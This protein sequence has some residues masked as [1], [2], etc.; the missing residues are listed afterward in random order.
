MERLLRRRVDPGPTQELPLPL[1]DSRGLA[2]RTAPRLALEDVVASNAKVK[3]SLILDQG[4]ET[5]IR[6]LPP[7]LVHQLV[8]VYR[9]AHSGV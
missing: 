7:T 3:L 1:R 9:Q 8:D 6:P 5:E 2:L 4:D